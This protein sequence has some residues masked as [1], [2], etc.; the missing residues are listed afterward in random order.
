MN[1]KRDSAHSGHPEL[2]RFVYLDQILGE[3]DLRRRFRFHASIVNAAASQGGC[4][5]SEQASESMVKSPCV[6]APKE[7]LFHAI[8]AQKKAKTG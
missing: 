5:G 2:A 4:A 1:R 7:A 8:F 6:F 3:N